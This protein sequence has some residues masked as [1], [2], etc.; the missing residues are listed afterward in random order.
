MI[1][2][3]SDKPTLDY[4]VTGQI[5][6]RRLSSLVET[7]GEIE[8]AA[9]SNDGDQAGTMERVKLTPASPGDINR[10]L[11]LARKVGL[12]PA[13]KATE[14]FD[15]VSARLTDNPDLGEAVLQDGIQ[16]VNRLIESLASFKIPAATEA[17]YLSTSEPKTL[18]LMPPASVLFI[19]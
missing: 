8:I 11:A 5:E 16:I 19:R 9:D 4:Y 1:N 10:V 2:D 7:N 17:R 12:L 3:K 13:L 15:S 6:L 14:F 18:R